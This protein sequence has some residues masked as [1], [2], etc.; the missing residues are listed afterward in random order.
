[1]A[2]QRCAVGEKTSLTYSSLPHWVQYSVSQKIPPE[3]LSQ[4]FQ[5]SRE[6][7]DQVLRAYYMFLS[8]LDNEFVF[9]YL[10]L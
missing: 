10:Q 1:M 6:F 2:A 9:N 5:N 4:F 3:V 7:F 8:T